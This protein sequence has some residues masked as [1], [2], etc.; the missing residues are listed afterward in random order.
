M[1]GDGSAPI[2]F[3]AAIAKETNTSAPLRVVQIDGQVLLKIMKH[4]TDCAPTLVTG[5]L[6]GLDIGQTLEVTDCFPF[7]VRAD[8]PPSY[9][10][11]TC[12]T[13][14]RL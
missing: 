9:A 10:H 11:T 7:P 1:A 6:L 3:A 13:G 5:Q 8:S 4:C 12:H 14:S 2:S